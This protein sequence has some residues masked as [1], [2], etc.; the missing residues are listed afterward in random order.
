VPDLSTQSPSERCDGD[1]ALRPRGRIVS[2]PWLGR[3]CRRPSGTVAGQL[4][5]PFVKLTRMGR[6]PDRAIGLAKGEAR[7]SA[8]GRRA[9]FFVP[10]ELLHRYLPVA[11]SLPHAWR[12]YL[13]W[14]VDST[15]TR[16][17]FQFR[18]IHCLEASL[19]IIESE[20]VFAATTQR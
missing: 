20:E 12:W 19:M 13:I 9:L 5:R 11:A 8:G 10:P 14:I 18:T 7:P 2:W 16:L 17:N 1:C 4:T 6:L 3:A 15:I